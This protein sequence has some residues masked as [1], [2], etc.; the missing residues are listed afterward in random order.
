MKVFLVERGGPFSLGEPGAK[1][2]SVECDFF[3]LIALETRATLPP[4][5]S[6]WA[7]GY[8]A[9]VLPAD[10]LLET[11][12]ISRSI[13]VIAYGGA[14]MAYPCFEAGAADYMREGWTRL[15]LEARLYRLWQPSIIGEGTLLRLRGLRLEWGNGESRDSH[16]IDLSP[17]DAMLLRRLLANAGR[18]VTAESLC[19]NPS[20]SQKTSKALGMRVSRLRARLSALSPHLGESIA[21]VRG[22]GYLWINR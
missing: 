9:C 7:R 19:A 20:S 21:T 17:G 1:E 3:P 2:Q 6:A 22:E 14:D 18:V 10:A 16:F 15:E 8:D 5:S 13:P 11:P 4:F 12:D